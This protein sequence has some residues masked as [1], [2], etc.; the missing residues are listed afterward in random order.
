MTDTIKELKRRLVKRVGYKNV[1]VT[2]GKG[3]SW[4]WV[5]VIFKAQIQNADG[6]VDSIVTEMK[7]EGYEFYRWDGMDMVSVSTLS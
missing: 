6:L 7:Q 1:S 5:K 3:T 4:G 2:N